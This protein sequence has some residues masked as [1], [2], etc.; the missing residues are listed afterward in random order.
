MGCPAEHNFCRVRGDTEAESITVT[1]DGSTAID[2]TGDSFLLTV[3]PSPD[4]ADDTANI[5]Q[6]A[7]VIVDGPNGIVSFSPSALQ[8]AAAPNTY[9]YDI[10]WTRTGSGSGSVKTIL[11]G[12]WE[13][14][15]DVTK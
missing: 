5:Y 10:Q 12:Q 7:G 3:D 15:Q 4:P 8:A 14:Q 1:T 9:F 2:I 11:K 6:I 13:I